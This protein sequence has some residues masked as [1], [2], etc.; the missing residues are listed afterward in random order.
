MPSRMSQRLAYLQDRSLQGS[1]V[2]SLFQ[3][4]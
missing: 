1:L 3:R 4:G 2:R